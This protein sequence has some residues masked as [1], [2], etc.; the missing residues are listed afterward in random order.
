MTRLL[1][2]VIRLVITLIFVEI[3]DPPIMRVTGFFISEVIFFNASKEN[4]VAF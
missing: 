2:F 1:T 4:I 3:L